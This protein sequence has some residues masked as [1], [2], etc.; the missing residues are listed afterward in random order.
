VFDFV[1]GGVRKQLTMVEIKGTFLKPESR[2]V[3]FRPFTRSIKSMF[4]LLP[5]QKQNTH[6]DTNNASQE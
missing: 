1:V 6:T 5:E 4:D 3:P 2:S